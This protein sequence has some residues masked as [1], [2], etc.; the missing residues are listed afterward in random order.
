MVCFWSYLS[1]YYEL[2]APTSLKVKG[3]SYSLA[4]SPL[5]VLFLPTSFVIPVYR[6]CIPLFSGL[7]QCTCQLL[8]LN[9]YESYGQSDFRFGFYGLSYA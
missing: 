9:N 3:E 8:Y 5:H 7:A 1:H 6:P 2:V 4:L